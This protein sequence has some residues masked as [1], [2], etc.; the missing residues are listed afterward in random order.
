[1]APGVDRDG[2]GNAGGT[3]PLDTGRMD[4]S[5]YRSY[6]IRVWRPPE[7]GDGGIRVVVEEVQSGRQVEMRGSTAAALASAVAAALPCPEERP[8]EERTVVRSAAGIVE[9]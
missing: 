7:V 9:E 6:V 5:R 8:A 1:M 3:V 4:G 2:S